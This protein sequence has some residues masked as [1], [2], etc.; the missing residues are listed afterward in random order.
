MAGKAKKKT[1]KRTSF[2]VKTVK[3]SSILEAVNTEMIKD[4]IMELRTEMTHY[5]V[6][7]TAVSM[8]SLLLFIGAPSV[9]PEIIN[10]YLPSSLKI[11]QAFIAVPTVFWLVTIVSN[12]FR[13]FKILRL[14]DLLKK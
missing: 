7:S 6:E 3:V 4:Q 11:M 8:L 10:P 12:M 14:Q 1:V 9:F 2:A 5:V 13:Y